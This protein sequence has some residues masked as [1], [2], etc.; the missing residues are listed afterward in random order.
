VLVPLLELDPDLRLPDGS[1]LR[2]ALDALGGGQSVNRAAP[3]PG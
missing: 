1:E 3:P 2:A